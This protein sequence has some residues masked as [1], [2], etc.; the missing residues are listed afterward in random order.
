[1]LNEF[2]KQHHRVENLESGVAQL[3][4]RFEKQDAKIQKVSAQ[5]ATAS[6]SGGGPAPQIVNN[7]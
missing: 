2:L 4:A 1:L 6:P 7:P 5:L 3:T